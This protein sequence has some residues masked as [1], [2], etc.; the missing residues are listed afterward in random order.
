[1]DVLRIHRCKLAGCALLW[2]MCSPAIS[3]PGPLILEETSRIVPPPPPAP[4]TRDGAPKAAVY[5]NSMIVLAKAG[6]FPP[7]ENYYAAFMYERPTQSAPWSLVGQL[8]SSTYED[9]VRRP[10]TVDIDDA[11]AVVVVP[12]AVRVFER[13]AAGWQQTAL[14]DQLSQCSDVAISSGRFVIGCATGT[15]TGFVYEKNAAGTWTLAARVEADFSLQDDSAFGPDVDLYRDRLVIGSQN[16]VHPPPPDPGQ[17]YFFREQAGSWLQIDH[18]HSTPVPGRYAGELAAL[19]KSTAAYNTGFGDLALFEEVEPDRWV[20]TQ[21][22][23]PIDTPMGGLGIASLDIGPGPAQD[24]FVYGVPGD[25]DRGA[26]SGSITLNARQSGNGVYAPVAKLLASDAR[27]DLNLGGQVSLHRRTLTANTRDNVYVFQL[28]DSFAQPGLRQDDFED[29]NSAGWNVRSSVWSVVS[30]L[31]SRVYRQTRTTGDARSI[32][33]GVDWTNQAIQADVRALT[34]DATDRWFGLAVRYIDDTNFY[35]VQLKR[36]NRVELRKQLNG[37]VTVL[38]SA[39]LTVTTN[40]DYR[41]RLEAVGTWLRAY[42]DGNLLVQAR[43]SALTHGT[44]GLRA[45]GAQTQYD[46]IVVSPNPSLALWADNFEDGNLESWTRQPQS[47]WS[48]V[49][50]GSGRVIRQTVAAGDARALAGIAYQ[51]N[52]TAQVDHIVEARA[53]ALSFISGQ[54]PWFGLIA[55]YRDDRNY[56]YVTV[57][58]NGYISLRKLVNGAIQVLDTTPM[59]VQTGTWYRLRLEAIGDRARVYA[60]GRP[61]LEAVDPATSAAAPGGLYGLMTSR[62]S[63]EFDDVK[64]IQP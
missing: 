30:S 1:M 19:F 29:G 22:L 31:G 17:I 51:P 43:D 48:N 21:K 42:V 16:F 33:D 15:E 13:S 46:N 9:V 3:W 2:A 5:G 36:S 61:V 7:P 58:R 38:G 14:L 37:V 23:L 35:Y 53:R 55:R 39:P 24:L 57:N 27:P 8:M 12:D 28:P 4:Y 64:V 6:R 60:N 26:G 32:L 34:L 45:F 41:V 11:L 59:T 40:R 52:E 56:T 10:Y 18:L 62:A 25:D 63:A 50:S 44:V 47:N 20:A 49:A 54:D